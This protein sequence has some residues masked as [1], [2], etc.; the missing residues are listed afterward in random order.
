MYVEY[1]FYKETYQGKVS[2]VDFPRLEIQASSIVDLYTFNRIG[3]P[4]E[5]VKF[6]VCELVDY[7]HDLEGT[8]NKEI[9]SEKVGTYSVTY[10]EKET[11]QDK[12]KNIVKKWL[13]LSGL[14][15]RGR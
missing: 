6:A 14:M 1:N 15:Y 4:D 3:E 9:A 10:V 2:S 5:K 8:G 12:Q 13:G 7:M 11:V